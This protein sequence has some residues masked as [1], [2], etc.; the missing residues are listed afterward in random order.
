MTSN[1]KGQQDSLSKLGIGVLIL[2][3]SGVAILFVIT[4]MTF[5]HMAISNYFLWAGVILGTFSAYA[6]IIYLRKEDASL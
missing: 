6:I 3:I 1:P 2:G 4:L 5:L